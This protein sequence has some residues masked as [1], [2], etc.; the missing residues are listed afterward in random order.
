MAYKEIHPQQQSRRDHDR[1]Q[2]G[3]ETPEERRTLE[4]LK[5]EQGIGNSG[6]CSNQMFN[7]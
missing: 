2:R 4:R 3:I 5:A 7:N 1:Q 6:G